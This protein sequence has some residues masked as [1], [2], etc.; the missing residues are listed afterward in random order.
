MGREGEWEAEVRWVETSHKPLPY[1]GLE[2]G[3]SLHQPPRRRHK[4][5]CK[6]VTLMWVILP[7][8]KSLIITEI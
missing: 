3:L 5:E 8:S 1:V 4:M 2:T 7:S 6:R